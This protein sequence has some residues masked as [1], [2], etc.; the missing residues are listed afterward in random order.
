M[1]PHDLWGRMFLTLAS[2]YTTFRKSDNSAPGLAQTQRL[3]LSWDWT[4][5][6][7]VG[8]EMTAFHLP[9]GDAILPSH[10]LVDPVE[11]PI[12]HSTQEPG[13]CRSFRR[14]GLER[15]R[16]GRSG[17]AQDEVEDEDD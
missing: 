7:P 5:E 8:I 6:G 4:T 13:S 10:H 2:K 9:N 16:I 3:W 14:L 17:G 15:Q 12:P 11:E 1:R